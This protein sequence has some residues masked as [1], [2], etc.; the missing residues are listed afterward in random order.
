MRRFFVA[1]AVFLSGC[2]SMSQVSPSMPVP[3]VEPTPIINRRTN[4]V[5][6]ELK[7][8]LTLDDPADLKVKQGDSVMKGQVIGDRTSAR[9]P[10]EQQRQVIR[11]KLENLNANA[12][13]SSSP[14]SYAVEQAR[15]RQAQVRVQQAREA[16]AQ[17]K[18]NSPWTDYAWASL[19]LYKESTQV[20]QLAIKAQDAEAELGLAVAQLQVAREN[21]QQKAV[22]QEPPVQQ[23]LLMSQLKDV[24]ARLDGV[25]VVRSPYDGTIK[26]IKWMNQVNQEL[27]VEITLT[28][29][30]L[31]KAL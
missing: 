25:G 17:F 10:L 22:G 7:L 16:I 18:T 1:I 5:P 11:L 26:K 4:L 6:R 2:N 3:V 19:P 23:A 14:V 31:D 30:A 28:V 8:K 27:V 29:Q 20:S 12:G 13:A 9:K 15:V 21:R 24:E